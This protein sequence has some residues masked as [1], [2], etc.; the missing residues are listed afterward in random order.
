MARFRQLVDE[1]AKKNKDVYDDVTGVFQAIGLLDRDMTYIDAQ[2]LLGEGGVLGYYDQESKELR[3]RAGQLTP[4]AR[5]VVVHELVHALDDQRF[6]LNRPQYDSSDDEI[7]FG[8][9]ALAE[10]NARRIENAY[11]NSMSTADKASATAEELR[12]GAAGAAVLAK[13]KLPLL[14]LEI[15][16]Y[17]LGEALVDAFLDKGG[18]AALDQAFA[19]PPRTSEQVIE[20]SKYFAKEARRTVNPPPADATPFKSGVF[21]EIALRADAR[22]G[23]L[24]EGR[25]DRGLRMGR[26]LVRGVERVEPL[27][28]AGGL[29]DGHRQGLDRAPRRP[30]QVG[31]VPP[32]GQ[33]HQL[34]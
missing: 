9:V 23:Q 15:A 4:Y 7:G 28:P 25:G 16:P 6:D 3:V 12:F 34:G 26:R 27:V 24:G 17:D 2:K 31:P 30:H 11:R 19:D 1:D 14:L 32:V 5:T 18:Q 13:L 33:G 22:G 29:R 8:F 10:G 20:P 21:G